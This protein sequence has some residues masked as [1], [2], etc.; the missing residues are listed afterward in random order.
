MQSLDRPCSDFGEEYHSHTRSN[1]AD[2]FEEN[3]AFN[4]FSLADRFLQKTNHSLS[5]TKF[6][7]YQSTIGSTAPLTKS[8]AQ[9]KRTYSRYNIQQKER[10]GS[11]QKPD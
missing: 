6:S 5:Y 9:K 1:F 10:I 3:K 11:L 4:R 7:G 2:I 8:W